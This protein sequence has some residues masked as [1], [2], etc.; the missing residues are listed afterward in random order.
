MYGILLQY[1]LC[2]I[3][4]VKITFEVTASCVHSK[5]QRTTGANRPFNQ[6]MIFLL[7]WVVIKVF[8]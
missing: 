3:A 5:I 1:L 4:V 6:S 7:N 8:I 2:F